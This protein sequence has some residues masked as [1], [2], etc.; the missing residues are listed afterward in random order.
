MGSFDSATTSLREVVAALGM[1]AGRWAGAPALREVQAVG[2]AEVVPGFAVGV[3]GVGFE[4]VFGAE[5]EAGEAEDVGEWED[6]PGV[7]GDDVGDDEIDFRKFVGDDA[8]V[9]VAADVDAVKAVRELCGPLDL[10]ADEARARAVVEE[11]AERG[12]WKEVVA[13]T[14]EDCVVAFAVAEGVR[15][16]EAT[17]GGG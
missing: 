3:V 5:E 1:T 11:G 12:E 4:A 17:A 2:L 13:V 15:D 6:E 16:S 14:I 10:D 8:S 9:E 7:F